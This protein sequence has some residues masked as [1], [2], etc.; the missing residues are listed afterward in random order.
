MTLSQW[1]R[2][3]LTAQ[4]EQAS[5]AKDRSAMIASRTMANRVVDNIHQQRE[6]LPADLALTLLCD[7]MG[8]KLNLD[9]VIE[10]Q[11]RRGR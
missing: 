3:H 9:D 7:A 10:R 5:I 2:G 8:I 4:T 11:L 6:H 1:V